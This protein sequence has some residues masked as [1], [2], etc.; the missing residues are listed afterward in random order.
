[1]YITPAI[2]QMQTL[3]QQDDDYDA[4]I[5][6]RQLDETKTVLQTCSVKSKLMQ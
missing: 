1:M 5:T 4:K 6:N 3:N 2:I